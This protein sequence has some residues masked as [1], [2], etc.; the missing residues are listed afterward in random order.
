VSLPRI[1]LADDHADVADVYRNILLS[2]CEVLEIVGDG[3]TAL[4]AAERYNPDVIVMDISM[5]VLDGVEACRRLRKILPDARVVLVS[6]HASA[7]YI[8]GAFQAGASG[9]LAKLKAASELRS[10]VHTVLG[11]G[12]Y[13][14]PSLVP[15]LCA[16]N[17]ISPETM[18][19]L[20]DRQ[21]Q[22]VTLVGQGL[23]TKEIASAMGITF[24]TVV[25]RRA[26]AMR[27]LK[28]SRLIHLT[29]YAICCR[30]A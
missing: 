29:R 23:T 18:Q 13:I 20:T 16:G 6:I 28:I 26:A 10:A 21:R 3:Q 7:A 1:L 17:A 30:V 4:E 5:P 27:R 15:L 8:T 2:E 11:G 25:R 9:Y 24:Q 14:S 22:L 19:R 12:A